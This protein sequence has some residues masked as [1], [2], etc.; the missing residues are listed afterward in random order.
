MAK[1][2]V[3]AFCRVW[4][5]ALCLA[6]VPMA[7]AADSEVVGYMAPSPGSDGIF[8]NPFSGLDGGDIRLRDLVSARCDGVRISFNNG[9]NWVNAVSVEA[10]DGTFGWIDVNTGESADDYGVPK[11]VG[12][13]YST[14]DGSEAVD[15]LVFSGSADGR[16]MQNGGYVPAF[17]SSLSLGDVHVP[18][19]DVL[20]ILNDNHPSVVTQTV[21]KVIERNKPWLFAIRVNDRENATN[22]LFLARYD[23]YSG[24]ILNAQTMRH[25]NIDPALIHFEVATDTK[26]P[27]DERL[28]AKQVADLED[29]YRKEY[30]KVLDE[31]EIAI[32]TEAYTRTIKD[33]FNW[34]NLMIAALGVAGTTIVSE[35]TREMYDGLARKIKELVAS[36]DWRKNAKG[37][38]RWIVSMMS[39]IRKNDG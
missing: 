17:S 28:S 12:I 1:S 2:G 31:Q 33:L 6:L 25:V 10:D 13:R 26:V 9:D 24:K 18:P 15:A 3:S 4:C 36:V 38:R 27:R 35:I 19:S 37:A 7:N 20:N 39:K 5:L 21:E 32:R 22:Y 23:E 34:F 8:V 16:L 11:G 30:R 29:V 14:M